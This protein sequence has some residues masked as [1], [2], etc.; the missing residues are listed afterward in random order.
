MI[1]AFTTGAGILADKF[2][3]GGISGG[4]SAVPNMSDAD[5]RQET[6]ATLSTGTFNVATG[7]SSASGDGANDPLTK[8][9]PLV[10]IAGVTIFALKKLM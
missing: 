1:S 4:G 3:G 5:G 7:G 9:V 2:M 10:L 8:L 6:N